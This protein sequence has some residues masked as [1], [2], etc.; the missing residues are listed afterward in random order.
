VAKPRPPWPP[1][2]EFQ[3]NLWRFDDADLRDQRGDVPLAVENAQFVES[4]SGY[5]L[6]MACMPQARFILPERAVDGRLNLSPA[7]G[8]IQFY[9]APDWTQ[10]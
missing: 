6:R 9:L 10:A 4:W 2:P 5:A 7:I 8:T 3:L 1:L